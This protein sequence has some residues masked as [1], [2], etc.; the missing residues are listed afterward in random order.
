MSTEL[1]A[2][3][4]N[5]KDLLPELVNNSLTRQF[6]LRLPNLPS[7]RELGQVFLELPKGFPDRAYA[8]IR[9]PK[10]AILKVP[11]IGA[12]GKLCIGEGDCGP[13]SGA[14]PIDRVQQL[15]EAFFS[16]FLKEWCAGRLDSDFTH[17]AQ[18]YWVIHCN[19]YASQHNAVTKIYIANEE[20]T[21]A[22][23]YKAKYLV[24]RR[25]VILGQTELAKRF[26]SV[27]GQSQQI[28]DVIVAHLQISYSLIPTTWPKD[29]QQLERLLRIRLDEEVARNF[30]SKKS[31]SNRVVHRVVILQAPNCSF[32]FLLPNGPPTIV[33]KGI[34]IRAYPTQRLTP[35]LVERIDPN[36]TFGRDQNHEIAS[37]QK[38]R[39]LIIGAGALGSSV[40]E[41]LAKAG[42]GH[43]MIVDGES[44]VAANIGRH[45]LG[46]DSIG[47]S[48]A[49]ML[50]IELASRWPSC[51]FEPIVSSIQKWL[52]NNNLS[53]IDLVLDLTGEPDVRLRIDDARNLNPCPLLIG[54]MEPYVAAAH[55]CLLPKNNSWIT[56]LTD[57]LEALQAVTWPPDVMQNEPACS[58]TFQSYTSAA[59]TH[60][61]A[62]ITES[63]LDLLDNKVSQPIVRD[64][65]RGQKFLD[66]HRKGLS[67][68]DWAIQA[69]LFDGVIME[70]PY[71]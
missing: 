53:N 13:L 55:A 61:V 30:L 48:K 64:W 18:N 68:R 42:I 8:A 67:L 26:V 17:E 11:H 54:W 41:Q 22:L 36:W 7:G 60:A 51:N 40:T 27:L 63:A 56:K 6:P 1:D 35:L 38:K 34:S 5:H 3:L 24:D 49:K 69:A 16:L 23:V 66:S 19:R 29:E 71:V 52:E 59:A 12:D 44:L 21:G 15:I 28:C 33:R 2:F 43:L 39:V 25:I 57:N 20:F 10:E 31:R 9:F 65:V 32:G 45:V 58:S 70:R 14:S 46:A 47:R 37:R 4:A 50:S 62:L